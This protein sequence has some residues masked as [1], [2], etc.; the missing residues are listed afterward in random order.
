[1]SFWEN[2][3]VKISKKSEEILTQ[4]DLLN[5]ITKN[6]ENCNLKYNVIQQPTEE[7]KSEILNFLNQNY[8][9]KNDMSFVYS[10]SLFSYAIRDSII[11]EFFSENRRIGL[12]IGMRKKITIKQE[13]FEITEVDFL[14]LSPDFRNLKFAPQMIQ[15]L[16]LE[17]IKVF[18][19]HRAYY[20]ISNPIKSECFGTKRMF[21]RPINTQILFE[22]GFFSKPIPQPKFHNLSK[23]EYIN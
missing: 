13:T 4:T 2:Q 9:Y 1:M 8:V 16:T 6:L 23:L 15:I 12:I 3:P 10:N 11:I 21:H 14:S 19:I 5:K 7:K 17:S 22:C 18:G 20:T